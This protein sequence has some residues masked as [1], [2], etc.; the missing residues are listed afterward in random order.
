MIMCVPQA[1][2]DSRAKDKKA[3]PESPAAVYEAALVAVAE[4]QGA[5]SA[6]MAV[7]V[8]LRGELKMLKAY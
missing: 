1:L 2:T 7:R 4:Q 3:E 8:A 5:P 6:S